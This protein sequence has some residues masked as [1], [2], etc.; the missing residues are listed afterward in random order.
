MLRRGFEPQS[1]PRDGRS[2]QQAALLTVF[3]ISAPRRRSRPLQSPLHAGNEKGTQLDALV[4]NLLRR[5]HRLTSR[6]H[7]PTQ[8]FLDGLSA[9]SQ[10]AFMSKP[11]ESVLREA[12]TTPVSLD[13]HSCH[14][15]SFR[16]TERI[17]AYA[18]YRYPRVSVHSTGRFHRSSRQQRRAASA[19][20]GRVGR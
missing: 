8:A 16:E 10:I 19:T 3:S 20:E 15:E 7:C 14:G 11:G 2:F 18:E 1:L 12:A 4:A 5:N 9:E 13:I 17:P 6:V